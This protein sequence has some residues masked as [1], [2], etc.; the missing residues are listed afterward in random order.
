MEQ[1]IFKSAVATVLN[2]RVNHI[3]SGRNADHYE[4]GN[5][6]GTISVRLIKDEVTTFTCTC[7][8][9]S[10]QDIHQIGL[11]SAVLSVLFYRFVEGV[12]RAVKLSQPLAY[13]AH[14][15]FTK[16]QRM[17][18]KIKKNTT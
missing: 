2:G 3:G 6:D 1:D 8:F 18:E 12:K 13:K 11:C 5:G 15:L 4:V 9:H 7:K 17:G 14:R 10:C 16:T